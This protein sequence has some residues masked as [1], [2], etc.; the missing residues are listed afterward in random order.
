MKD[1][2]P[3]KGILNFAYITISFSRLILHAPYKLLVQR[4]QILYTPQDI[5]RYNFNT[6]ISNFMFHK[7]TPVQLYL[8]FLG[9]HAYVQDFFFVLYPQFHQTQHDFYSH[10]IFHTTLFDLT[11][12]DY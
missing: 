10:T 9:S 2:T 6:R 4:D 3:R 7:S 5:S 8:Y 11:F 1:E 12:R